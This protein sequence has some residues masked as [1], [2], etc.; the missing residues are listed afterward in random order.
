[1]SADDLNTLISRYESLRKSMGAEA[2]SDVDQFIS[3]KIREAEV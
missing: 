3:S 2:G 1:M